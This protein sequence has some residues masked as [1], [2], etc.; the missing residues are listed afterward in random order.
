MP[1]RRQAH[2]GPTDLKTLTI[3]E[4]LPPPHGSFRGRD[5]R[6]PIFQLPD[7]LLVA[8]VE[9]AASEPDARSRAQHRTFCNNGTLLILSRICQRLRRLAQPLLYRDICILDQAADP[10]SVV[11]PS[12]PVIKLHRTLR[13]RADLRQHCRSLYVRISN[14]G[15]SHRDEYAYSIAEDLADWLTNTRRLTVDGGF[16][17]ETPGDTRLKELTYILIRRMTANFANLGHLNIRRYSGGTNSSSVFKWLD[18]PR[19]KTLEMQGVF[20]VNENDESVEL[21]PEVT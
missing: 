11:P 17:D 8:I 21:A 7:E 16:S 15:L 14:G 6:T 2:L 9:F 12:I 19:L 3:V 13:N 4:F 20:E 1:L 5:R 10:A 18:C